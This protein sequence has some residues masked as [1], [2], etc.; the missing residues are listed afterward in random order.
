MMHFSGLAFTGEKTARSRPRSHD[1]E[2]LYIEAWN[3]LSMLTV[4]YR[5]SCWALEALYDIGLRASHN[6]VNA[7]YVLTKESEAGITPATP[8][9]WTACC[10]RMILI[11]GAPP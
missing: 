2:N 11:T 10:G 3:P 5:V 1:P 4:Q 9:G 6:A 7:S 8:R